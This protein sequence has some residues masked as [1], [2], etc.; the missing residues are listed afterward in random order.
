L[1]RTLVYLGGLFNQAATLVGNSAE[2]VLLQCTM[3]LIFIALDYMFA[4]K[5]ARCTDYILR[6]DAGLCLDTLSFFTVHT[7]INLLAGVLM[8]FGATHFLKMGAIY[9]SHA[10]G[11]YGFVIAHPLSS[12]IAYFLVFEMLG[13]WVHRMFHEVPALWELHKFHHSA[14]EFTGMAALRDHPMER[15]I[16]YSASTIVASL[17]FLESKSYV[18]LVISH[19]FVLIG[20]FKHSNWKSDWGWA[21]KYLLQSPLH[22]RI[23]HGM[24]ECYHNKNYANLFQFYDIL[25]GTA[26]NPSTSTHAIPIGVDG[27]YIVK[28]FGLNIFSLWLEGFINFYKTAFRTKAANANKKTGSLIPEP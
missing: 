16:Q 18:V 28:R 13:Y 23:H 9:S 7:R 11:F 4:E 27:G 14:T 6:R 22:H 8:F 15:A 1:E 10:L 26:K 25:F 21:G 2:F 20:F 5:G 3:F 19:V 12:F 17:L 24:E